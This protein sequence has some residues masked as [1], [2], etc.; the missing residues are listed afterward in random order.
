MHTDEDIYSLGMI[1]ESNHK[2]PCKLLGLLIR[3]INYLAEA[4]VEGKI[5]IAVILSQFQALGINFTVE[6]HPAYLHHFALWAGCLD[7][8]QLQVTL[9]AVL[10]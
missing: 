1:H 7:K 6:T 5:H 2:F 8:W 10:S 4:H 9:L 3:G